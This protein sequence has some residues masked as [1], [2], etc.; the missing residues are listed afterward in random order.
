MRK[1][2]FVEKVTI[3]GLAFLSIITLAFYVYT[4][5]MEANLESVM[6]E[7]EQG[8]VD[9]SMNIMGG[10]RVVMNEVLWTDPVLEMNETITLKGK[11]KTLEQ[12]LVEA[13]STLNKAYDHFFSGESWKTVFLCKNARE[14]Y[15]GVNSNASLK[16][17][18]N[19]LVE[20]SHNLNGSY[21]RDAE[22]TVWIKPM[23]SA[24]DVVTI[25]GIAQTIGEWMDNASSSLSEAY[26]LSAKEKYEES[27]N[28]A[29]KATAIYSELNQEAYSTK[30]WSDMR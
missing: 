16:R 27:Q 26:T 8:L 10:Y 28:M 25:S 9:A 23:L 7:S 1:F 3:W 15:Q 18:E 14:I 30:D 22:S 21:K 12:W 19:Q 13:G 29:N 5:N 4:A 11:T 20:F 24:N 6:S 2:S 17:A